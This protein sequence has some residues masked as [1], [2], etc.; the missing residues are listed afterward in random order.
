MTKVF[1]T[2]LA[3][4]LVA[5]II[6]AMTG[7]SEGKPTLKVYNWGDYIDESVLVEF[8]EEY[9]IRVIYDT[10]A[11]NEDMYIKIKAG[12]SDYDV[13]FP[14]DYMIERMIKED[15][16]H[17]IDFNNIPN[18][19]YISEEFK[20]LDYDSSNNY[21]VPYMWGT[22]G[23]IYNT[24]MVDDTVDSW[25]ILWNEKYANQILML[26]SQ[27]DSIGITLKKLGYSLNTRD[28]NELE[29]VKDELIKQKP[30]V[31]AYVG[32]DVKDKM[33]SEEAAMAVVWSGDAVYMKWQNPNLEYAIP[34]EGSN[35][36]FDA[37]VIPKTSKNKENAEL[38]INFMTS[39]D[40][41]FKNT[42]YIGYSTPH[43]EARKLLD[44]E[45]INDKTAYP[46]SE[47]LANCEVFKDLS[48]FLTEYDRVWT[49]VKAR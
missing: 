3:L 43:V 17:E 49:E 30:L 28:V 25:D 11:T 21:S 24:T 32:D 33:I 46:S 6:L 4:L 37:M 44:D 26:D 20:N 15:L 36:W 8:E 35:L 39:T 48:D 9:G 1:K 47:D 38:F 7:C 2:T 31:L 19:K 16:L 27:R 5:S 42:D 18:F 14:S 23:I 22:V 29:A 41:A 40:I 34:K 45:L 13:A 12:G 10:Y